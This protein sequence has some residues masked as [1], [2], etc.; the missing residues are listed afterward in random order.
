MRASN[1]ILSLA[2]A[3]VFQIPL[4]GSLAAESATTKQAAP[5]SAQAELKATPGNGVSG[6]L[7][8]DAEGSGVRLTGS[9]KG[10]KPNST[11]GFHVHEK[12]DCS[13]P[14]ATSAGGHYNP[15][16]HAHGDPKGAE[17]HLGDMPNLEADGTGTATLDVVVKNATLR[18]G[19]PSDL[20]GKAVI[21]H[22]GPDDYKSQ[23]AGNSGARI[24]CGI[25]K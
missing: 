15:T 7:T 20:V 5:K 19:E 12:G 23:P 6:T 2:V 10:L 11:H 1:V 16:S 18:T 8:F 25:I 14:D 4:V 13:A 24:A 22:A 21:V 17:H 9:V 3:A